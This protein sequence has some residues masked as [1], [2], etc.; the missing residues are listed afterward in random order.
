M[1]GKLHLQLNAERES[2]HKLIE[3]VEEFGLEQGWTPKL[4]FQT[5]LVLEELVINVINHG[6]RKSG[7]SLEVR[8]LSSPQSLRID[9]ADDAWPFNPLSD[10]PEADLETALEDRPVGGLGVHLVRTM[11]DELR[12]VREDGK[13]HLTL[14]RRRGG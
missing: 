3:A 7:Q 2:I 1:T 14:I 13:N 4:L 8:I 9:L 12:Y 6:F 10:T 5:Q 11:M